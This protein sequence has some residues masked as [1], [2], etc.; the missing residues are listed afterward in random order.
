MLMSPGK[1]LG[2]IHQGPPRTTYHQDITHPHQHTPLP[3][4][5][6]HAQEPRPHGP[7]RSLAGGGEVQARGMTDVPSAHE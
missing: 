6:P 3:L 2:W 5:P 4:L 1:L 7:R